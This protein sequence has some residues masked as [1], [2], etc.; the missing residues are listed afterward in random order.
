MERFWDDDELNTCVLNEY[1]PQLSSCIKSSLSAPDEI[2][3]ELT[4][5]LFWA[6]CNTLCSF[7]RSKVTDDIGVLKRLIRPVLLTEEEVPLLDVDSD[8]AE[9]IPNPTPSNEVMMAALFFL[10]PAGEKRVNS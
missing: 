1:V 4:C 6:G 9:F 10:R 3:D 2:I 7:I 5:R 8:K